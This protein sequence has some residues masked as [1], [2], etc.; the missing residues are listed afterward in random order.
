VLSCEPFPSWWGEESLSVVIDSFFDESG[1]ARKNLLVVSAYFGPTRDMRKLSRKWKTE[2]DEKEVEYFHARD[3]RRRHSGVFKHL[4]NTKR[5]DL[6][7]K[8]LKHIERHAEGGIT[9]RINTEE[10]K[11]LTSERFRSQWGAAYSFCV[12]LILLR[13][14]LILHEERRPDHPVNILIE[15]GHQNANQTIEIL[16]RRHSVI[17]IASYGLGAK[18]DHAVLQAADLLAYSSSDH[19]IS[20]D[21][22]YLFQRLRSTRK[23]TYYM[24]TCDAGIIEIAKSAVGDHIK[25][26]QEALHKLWVETG[27]VR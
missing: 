6:L 14:A 17:R 12:Q 15:D 13:L 21:E 18:R 25:K 7:D 16:G 11:K 22:S 19:T 1:N 8:L 27:K 4:S 3:Y 9:A 26:F 10:Y 2:L 5:K 23:P 20:P 24:I